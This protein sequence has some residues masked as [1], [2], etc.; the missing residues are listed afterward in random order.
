LFVAIF[1]FTLTVLSLKQ[2]TE[3]TQVH[4]MD[5]LAE[6][7]VKAST[8]VACVV[9]SMDESTDILRPEGAFGL[10]EGSKSGLHASWRAGAQSPTI[11][12]FRKQQ[13]VLVPNTRAFL[14]GNEL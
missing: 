2:S 14:L 5:A 3:P 10:P 9:A 7:V 6:G 12:V 11:E 13:S 4:M 8:P 1:S